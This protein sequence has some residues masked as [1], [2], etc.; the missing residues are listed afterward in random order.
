MYLSLQTAVPQDSYCRYH[1]WRW[2]S[3]RLDLHR[4]TEEWSKGEKICELGDYFEGASGTN[5][6]ISKEHPY[7]ITEADTIWLK[8]IEDDPLYNDNYQDSRKFNNVDTKTTWYDNTCVNYG[9]VYTADFAGE[10]E[11]V[12]T[13]DIQPGTC[14]DDF[15]SDDKT[16]CETDKYCDFSNFKCVAKKGGGDTCKDSNNCLTNNCASGSCSDPKSFE[17]PCES[18]VE[19]DSRV[20]GV[21]RF[22]NET[23]ASGKTCCP[24]NSGCHQCDSDSDCDDCATCDGPSG[25][26]KYDCDFQRCGPTCDA[27]SGDSCLET[28]P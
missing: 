11:I 20:C 1:R 4:S 26:C 23:N 10:E 14:P 3:R 24:P 15:C 13:F 7:S 27:C 5:F 28:N 6:I 9:A 16:D 12:Y 17:D 19:C 2:G 22:A 8:V 18:P 25:Y 21:I